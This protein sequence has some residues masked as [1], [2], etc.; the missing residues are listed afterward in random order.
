[1]ILSPEKRA[2]S[3]HYDETWMWAAGLRDRPV[4]SLR[5][6]EGYLRTVNTALVSSGGIHSVPAAAVERC[7]DEHNYI[8]VI[9][10]LAAAVR[11][12]LTDV[13]PL[14][15]CGLNW[16]RPGHPVETAS[17]NNLNLTAGSKPGCADT[18]NP[19]KS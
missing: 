13:C 7:G 6:T 9:P 10:N 12:V 2:T 15:A 8:A 11:Q 18:K 5:D 1:M 14:A 19:R 16:T 3:D 4:C 17:I